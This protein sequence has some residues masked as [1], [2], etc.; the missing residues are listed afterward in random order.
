[1]IHASQ[2]SQCIFSSHLQHACS[3]SP[4]E[5]MLL[6]VPKPGHFRDVKN[7]SGARYNITGF[8]SNK[9][10]TKKEK[11]ICWKEYPV[12]SMP[13]EPSDLPHYRKK[14]TLLYLPCP[15]NIHKTFFPSGQN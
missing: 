6:F 5:Q 4:F 8:T 2:L 10:T 9:Q 11:V 13:L 7:K 15:E 3:S 14:L 1:M 12:V